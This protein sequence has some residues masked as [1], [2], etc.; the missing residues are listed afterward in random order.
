VERRGDYG[1]EGCEKQKRSEF[2][3]GWIYARGDNSIH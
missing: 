1:K 3:H 2:R